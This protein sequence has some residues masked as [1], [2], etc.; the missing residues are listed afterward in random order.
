MLIGRKIGIYT[1][2]IKFIRKGEPMIRRAFLALLVFGSALNSWA[3][4]KYFEI[5]VVVVQNTKPDKPS[6]FAG[7]QE[8]R[9]EKDSLFIK[10]SDGTE[11]FYNKI[12]ETNEK[13]RFTCG[14]KFL[15]FANQ[16]K[17]QLIITHVDDLESKIVYVKK[18]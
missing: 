17:D 8:Y 10:R 5:S 2:G 15:V 12:V 13:I 7:S 14:N 6:I 18:K 3:G 1:A 16:A 9:I 4:T 11:Y